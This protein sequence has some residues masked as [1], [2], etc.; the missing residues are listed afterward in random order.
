MQ[1]ASNTKM[2]V[3]L[4]PTWAK[5]RKVQGYKRGTRT[6]IYT[7]MFIAALLTIAEKWKQPKC[8][9]MDEWI[10]KRWS[11]H[12]MEYY[13]TLKRKE[14]LTHATTWMNL[15][16]ITLSEIIQTQKD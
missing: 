11:I 12:T 4:N 9:W 1:W 8:P 5:F 6:D 2:N 7:P 15:K 14:I 3:R 13:S 16:D 10:N